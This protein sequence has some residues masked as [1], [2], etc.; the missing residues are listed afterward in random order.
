MVRCCQ[1]NLLPTLQYSLA[2]NA[3]EVAK[4]YG[5]SMRGGADV[6]LK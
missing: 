3:L 6:D 5:V 2:A 1:H 4:I